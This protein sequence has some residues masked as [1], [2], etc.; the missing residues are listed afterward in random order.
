MNFAAAR[1]RAKCVKSVLIITGCGVVYPFAR[2][3]NI[4]KASIENTGAPLALR[5]T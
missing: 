4:C 5:A 3:L 1:Q 2:R